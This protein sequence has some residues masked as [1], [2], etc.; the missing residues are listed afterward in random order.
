MLK[1]HSWSSAAKPVP[2]SATRH[3]R[4]IFAGGRMG[5]VVEE[6]NQKMFREGK[7][8][9]QAP[10]VQRMHLLQEEVK[11][12][13]CREARSAQHARPRSDRAAG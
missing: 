10:W 6:C 8:V 3:R 11:A 9:F 1:P 12:R 7:T 4:A 13:R 2:E 5:A